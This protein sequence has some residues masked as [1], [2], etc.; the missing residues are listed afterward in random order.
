MERCS[1]HSPE[2]LSGCCMAEVL[3]FRLGQSVKDSLL[4]TSRKQAAECIVALRSF[5]IKVQR[6]RECV[7]FNF[8]EGRY[9]PENRDCLHEAG[10]RAW[11]EGNTG[12]GV[13]WALGGEGSFFVAPLDSSESRQTK[14][15]LKNQALFQET[16][17][18]HSERNLCSPT[19]KS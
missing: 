14:A 10:H 5:E 2:Q 6:G 7:L 16:Y 11:V 8:T 19:P 15:L 3:A 1:L 17:E 18:G 13:S 9:V 4:S 12:S